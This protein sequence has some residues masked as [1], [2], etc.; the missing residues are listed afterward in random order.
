MPETTIEL[1]WVIIA[2]EWVQLP[3]VR[4]REGGDMPFSLAALEKHPDLKDAAERYLDQLEAGIEAA[5]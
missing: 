3:Y 2:D 4:A 1:K 5:S